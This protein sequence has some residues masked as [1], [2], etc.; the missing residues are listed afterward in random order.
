MS[1]YCFVHQT[2]IRSFVV[3]IGK[4]SIFFDIHTD[5]YNTNAI[6]YL[7]D[8]QNVHISYVSTD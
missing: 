6:Q 3:V 1:T 4:K 8:D 5:T 7:N 2:V